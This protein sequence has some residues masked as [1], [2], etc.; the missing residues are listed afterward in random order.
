MPSV[1][2]PSRRDFLRTAPAAAVLGTASLGSAM[3]AEPPALRII[4]PHVHVWKN[5]AKY[6]WPK[7]LAKPPKD[8]ALPSTL[9]DLMKANDVEKTVIV[10]VIHYQW[11]CRYAGDTIKAIDGKPVVSQAQLQQRLGPKYEGDTVSI[12]IQRGKEELK[13]DKVVLEGAVAAYSQ[14]FLG[15]LPIRDDP[16]PGVEIRY[17]YPGSPADTAGLKVGDRV[18]KIGR[19]TRPGQT[20]LQAIQSRDQLLTMMQATIPGLELAFEVKRADGKKT[21]SIKIKLG[22]V[23]VNANY[24]YTEDELTALTRAQ[25]PGHCLGRLVDHGRVGRVDLPQAGQAGRGGL[26]HPGDCRRGSGQDLDRMKLTPE[27]GDEARCDHA[28][29]SVLDHGAPDQAHP[30][31]ERSAQTGPPR[32]RDPGGAAFEPRERS[33]VSVAQQRPRGGETT[34]FG[35]RLHPEIHRHDGHRCITIAA[36]RRSSAKGSGAPMSSRAAVTRARNRASRRVSPVASAI[37]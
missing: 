31:A 34:G 11:D 22:A 18:M 3:S 1:S 15:I 16:Q 27:H 20:V 10:H 25:V 35:R 6:P 5:D 13:L 8:D 17:I 2:L 14:P 29:R 30:A 12:T 37:R 9:L 19:E 4:D 24:R 33:F 36:A 21:E 28:S 7:D 26:S 23:P 32:H